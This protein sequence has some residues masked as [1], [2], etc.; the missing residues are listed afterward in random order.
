[1]EPFEL[2]D[3]ERATVNRFNERFA[4]L[5]HRVTM[6]TLLA[7]W[8]S[9]VAEVERGYAGSIDDYTND[10]TSRDLL[11]DLIR[12]SQPS[13]RAKLQ[14]ALDPWDERSRQATAHDDGRALSRFFD[15]KDGWWWRRTP[16]K[17]LL[18]TYLRRHSQPD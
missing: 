16:T 18:A 4:K 9:L 8:M 14:E 2:D 17:G 6:E 11:Q 5:R 15:F 7:N 10:L 3:M 13:L 12:D 1:V